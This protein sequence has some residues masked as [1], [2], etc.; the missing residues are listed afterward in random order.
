MSTSYRKGVSVALNPKKPGS[1]ILLSKNSAF[2]NCSQR[3]AHSSRYRA[4]IRI[5]RILFCILSLT[6]GDRRVERAQRMV[7]VTRYTRLLLHSLTP[8]SPQ[9]V[10]TLRLWWRN[11]R[12]NI[13]VCIYITRA[14]CR[15]TREGAFHGCGS[16]FQ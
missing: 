11:A 13:T 12:E 5:L 16:V 9:H 10:P 7:L 6:L 1:N 3:I 15:D 8:P 2:N 4:H 14:S